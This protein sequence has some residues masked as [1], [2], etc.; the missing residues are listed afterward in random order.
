M[1][2]SYAAMTLYVACELVSFPITFQNTVLIRP[3]MITEFCLSVSQAISLVKMMYLI[4]LEYSTDD[5]LCLHASSN[6][7]EHDGSVCSANGAW[8]EDKQFD[9]RFFCSAGAK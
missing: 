7:M 8:L 6:D 3:G 4:P 2:A 9:V 1:V 5:N